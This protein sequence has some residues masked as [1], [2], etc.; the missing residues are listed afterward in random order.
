MGAV[1]LGVFGEAFLRKVAGKPMPHHLT[2]DRRELRLRHRVG[3][4]VA[5]TWSNGL[6]TIVSDTIVA[7]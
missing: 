5:E 1:D 3:A 4:V 7:L 2:K 6:Q